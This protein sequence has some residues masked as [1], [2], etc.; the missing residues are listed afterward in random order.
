MT[1]FGFSI[2]QKK[3]SFA[4]MI[5]YDFASI[6]LMKIMENGTSQSLQAEVLSVIYSW[7]QHKL[8]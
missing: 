1:A 8:Q 4:I 7:E 2:N 6:R 5:K 3:Q